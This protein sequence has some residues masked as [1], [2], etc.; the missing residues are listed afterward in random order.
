MNTQDQY[1]ALFHDCTSHCTGDG[2]IILKTRREK[3][4]RKSVPA[5]HSGAQQSSL[6]SAVGGRENTRHAIK[7][8]YHETVRRNPAMPSSCQGQP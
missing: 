7:T 5:S 1:I 2:T 6:Y 4:Q 3:P 8:C